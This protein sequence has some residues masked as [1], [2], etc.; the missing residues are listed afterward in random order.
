MSPSNDMKGKTRRRFLANA[1]AATAAG[2]LAGPVSASAGQRAAEPPPQ[3]TDT[4]IST[5]DVILG[6]R[7]IGSGEP[8]VFHPSL[9]RGAL[10]FD[11]LARL[12]AAAAIASYRS[13]HGESGKAGPRPPRSKRTSRSTAT[14]PTCSR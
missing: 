5:G 8:I 13:T 10:D 1:S 6:R 14:R 2:V 11:P 3:F 7:S 4:P 9:A 12:L